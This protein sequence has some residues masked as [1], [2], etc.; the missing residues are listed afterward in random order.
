MKYL[1]S[2]YQENVSPNAFEGKKDNNKS[3][4]NVVERKG[5]RSKSS[6]EKYR[7]ERG[8]PDKLKNKCPTMQK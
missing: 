4:N 1:G 5:N 6:K 3:Q 8:S 2:Y 7:N